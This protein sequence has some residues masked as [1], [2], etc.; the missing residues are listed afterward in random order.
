LLHLIRY[1]K[2]IATAPEN[3][4]ITSH[5]ANRRANTSRM[6]RYFS[7]RERESAAQK[8]NAGADLMSAPAL[9]LEQP[10]RARER[11]PIL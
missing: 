1:P 3:T 2:L 7:E 11:C 4:A 6:F 9:F 10:V 8:H 5:P